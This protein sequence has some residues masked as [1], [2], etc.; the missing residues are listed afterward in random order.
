MTNHLLL[1]SNTTDFSTNTTSDFRVKL[2]YSFDF[3]GDWE[4]AMTEITYPVSWNTIKPTEGKIQIIYKHNDLEIPLRFKV[5]TGFYDNIEELVGAIRY[6]LT[7]EGIRLPH[8]LYK[9]DWLVFRLTQL[10]H[11]NPEA[12]RAWEKLGYSFED[13]FHQPNLIPLPSR[14][15]ESELL[16]KLANNL[17]KS[18]RERHD[19]V[20]KNH[21]LDS[22]K[23][24]YNSI[25]K[26]VEIKLDKNTIKRIDLDPV[27]QFVLG[28][29]K[30]RV[31]ENKYNEADYNTDL[32]AGITSFYIYSNI[33]QP[34]CVGNS[35]QQLLRT[36]PLTENR[37][38]NIVHK[39]FLS[40]HLSS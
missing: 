24:E 16:T 31:I 7:A 18:E 12:F 38:G 40:P 11:N 5:N 29:N 15:V 13:T 30:R 6:A 9:A 35:V 2:P 37:L 1:P 3:H 14:G 25:I 22:V 20:E 34:Q 33:V 39:E 36:V 32:T 10:K 19:K 23:I 17:A 27:L 26:K 21:I 28:F 8:K 4:V